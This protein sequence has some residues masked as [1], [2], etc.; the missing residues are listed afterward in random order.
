MIIYGL[1]AASIAEDF[2]WPIEKA[3]ECLDNYFKKFSGLYRWIQSTMEL[4]KAQKWIELPTG[5]RVFV[6]EA[7]AKGI[8]GANSIG[9]KACNGMVQAL[10]AEM[11]KLALI[12]MQPVLDERGSKLVSVVH[13]EDLSCTLI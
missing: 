9:R 13:D 11:S 5:R 2:N 1:V 6:G 8:E 3:Q 4:G 7:N 12:Y 10:A